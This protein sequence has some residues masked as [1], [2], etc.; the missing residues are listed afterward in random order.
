MPFFRP[1]LRRPRHLPLLLLLA[2]CALGPLLRVTHLHALARSE[3]IFT[4]PV[5]DAGEYY[6]EAAARAAGTWEHEV[7]LHGVLYPLLLGPAY[8][9]TG[10][11]PLRLRLL[12]QLV[13]LAT[14]ALLFV[15]AKR[16]LG[17]TSAALA[18]LLFALY[19]PGLLYECEFYAEGLAA[20]AVLGVAATLV[21]ARAREGWWHCALAGLCI[22]LA[23]LCRSNLLLLAPLAGLLLLLPR[24]LGVRGPPATLARR[25]LHVVSLLA[26][27][28]LPILP[29]TFANHDASGEWV[30]LQ[31][32]GGHNLWMANH[33][34]SDGTPDIR[35]GPVFES[36]RREPIAHERI[37]PSAESAYWG[38]RFRTEL[39]AD[40]LAMLALWWKKLRLVFSPLEIPSSYDPEGHALHSWVVAWMPLPGF[41][42]LLPFALLGLL[43]WPGGRESRLV[44]LAILLGVGS[45]LVIG[46]AAGRYRH[47]LAPL[48]VLLAAA[49]LREALRCLRQDPPRAKIVVLLLLALGAAL[50]L[51][52]PRLDAAQERWRAEFHQ[53]QAHAL[54][55]AGD[56]EGCEREARLAAQG[57][58]RAPWPHFTLGRLAT[59]DARGVLGGP[60]APL[61]RALQHY[62]DA[63]ERWPDYPEAHENR[64]AIFANTG[65][66]ELAIAELEAA[67]R[68]APQRYASWERLAELLAR[69]GRSEE[70]R[71]CNEQARR[72][73]ALLRAEGATAG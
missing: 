34:G 70:A 30:L 64:A 61:E 39:R 73:R 53:L 2:A 63:L 36:L 18:V 47:Q 55:A 67:L 45:S 15:L 14:G 23:A 7:P 52:A 60:G 46:F 21:G 42:V 41:A 5:V 19:R 68:L 12:Q 31:A 20:L 29:L 3:P 44:L 26:A 58:P 13:P 62:A 9:A 72:W 28:A 38:E 24:P 22:G 32:R 69:A 27:C 8:R 16:L 4:R 56:R 71:A 59:F 65:R 35:P 33:P 1:L 25:L 50:P 49:G 40:P 57:D 66:P 48:L 11:D 37:G 10:G 6:E 17:P 43:R 51:G 54:Y